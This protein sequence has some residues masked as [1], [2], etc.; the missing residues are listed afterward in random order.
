MLNRDRLTADR[1][2][3]PRHQENDSALLNSGHTLSP[4]GRRREPACAFRQHLASFGTN[5]SPSRN[6][7]RSSAA[8]FPSADYLLKRRTQ[9]LWARGFLY[10]RIL[11]H[12]SATR[13]VK[14]VTKRGAKFILGVELSGCLMDEAF[15][16]VREAYSSIPPKRSCEPVRRDDLVA[17]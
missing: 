15:A 7:L 9:S 5:I 1:R 4:A 10:E 14:H 12:C 2:A 17:K 8:K 6:I 11:E 13:V 16:L 3:Q